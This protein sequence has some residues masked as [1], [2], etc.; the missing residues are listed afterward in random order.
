V[1]TS[2][3]GHAIVD[4]ILAREGIERKVALNLPSFLGVARI[5]A[6]TELLAIV[7]YRYASALA[8]S[9]AVR[10]F[11]VPVELS[12]FQVSS[13]G[14]NAIT[15]MCRTAGCARSLLRCSAPAMKCAMP[16]PQF[17][18]SGTDDIGVFPA[19]RAA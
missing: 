14:T 3:T 17:A 1:C 19:Q 12:S 2:G 13:T 9:E 8:D 10:Q 6:Q 7:P 11:P 5:V 18:V 15:P 4:K 16:A